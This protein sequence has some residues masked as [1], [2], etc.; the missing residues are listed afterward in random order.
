[1]LRYQLLEAA[2]AGRW[3]I[4]ARDVYNGFYCCI[5]SCR[6]AYRWATVPV[7]Q[8]AQLEK[9]VDLPMELREPWVY[10]QRHFGCVSE[11]GNNSAYFCIVNA[12]NV[13]ITNVE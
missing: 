9:E 7:V 4:F 5:A 12:M 13:D 8:V 1:L 10:L 6:H 2:D 11:S 3:D